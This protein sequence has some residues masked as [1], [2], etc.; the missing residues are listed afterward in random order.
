MGVLSDLA[1]GSVNQVEQR[2]GKRAALRTLVP[3]L[4]T[5]GPEA[6]SAA[7]V[8]A[9]RYATELNDIP[10]RKVL[11]NRWAADEHGR[12]GDIRNAIREMLGGRRPGTA[13]VLARAEVERAEGRY[14]EASARYLLAR[15]LERASAAE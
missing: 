9:L 6:R 10:Q 4:D 5:L 1:L 2:L 12:H 15:C 14:E 7:L 3:L 8:K 13:T 11:A